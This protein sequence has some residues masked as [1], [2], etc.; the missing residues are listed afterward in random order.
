MKRI[1]PLLLF[2]SLCSCSKEVITVERF[3]NDE[4]LMS[5]F[6]IKCNNGELHKEDINCINVKQ[7]KKEMILE[8]ELKSLKSN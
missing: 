2:F 3:K 8:D 4:K 1:I 7:A 5:E 6:I